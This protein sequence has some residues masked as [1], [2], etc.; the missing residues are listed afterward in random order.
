MPQITALILL[1]FVL[2]AWVAGSEADEIPVLDLAIFLTVLAV[3]LAVQS[4]LLLGLRGVLRKRTA[5]AETIFSAAVSGLF[6]ANVYF[7]FLLT[8]EAPSFVRVLLALAAG[9]AFFLLAGSVRVRAV[10]PLFAAAMILMSA[11][12]YGYARLIMAQGTSP[13]TVSLPVKSDRNVYIIGFESL[14]SPKAFRELYDVRDAPHVE[15]LKRLGF[16]VF[17][18]SY[19][20][21]F[22]T[23]SSYATMFEFARALRPGDLGKREVF[24]R[25]NS[26]FRSFHDSGYKIQFL[27][28]SNY[29]GLDPRTVDHFYPGVG[30]DSCKT[31]PKR[32]FYGFC[33]SR[34]V[35]LINETVFGTEKISYT[36]QIAH[37][38]KRIDLAVADKDPW[39]TISH[40]GHPFHTPKDFYWSDQGDIADFLTEMRDALPQIA[41]NVDATV[42]YIL[43]R[44]PD[45]V[46]IV[47][48]DH[49]ATMSRGIDVDSVLAGGVSAFPPKRFLEDRHGAF[50]AIYP[51]DFCTARTG[52]PIATTYLM[53]AI[54]ACLNDDDE[55][56]EAEKRRMRLIDLNGVRRSIDD[57]LA[58][59]VSHAKPGN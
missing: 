15:A 41:K 57:I 22:T 28:T 45:A 33:R 38:Q 50:L 7:C 55:P 13:G 8:V 27:Y 49:G 18:Q 46:V 5:R 39:L 20:S 10:V 51:A 59:A 48:G 23:L 24:L 12:Q 14:H 34:L 3:I 52:E 30:F 42:A 26:T 56:D 35:D 6:A 43:A 25:P 53:P 11:A 54:I 2:F 19:S 9:G 1:T 44:D 31:V 4:A 17:D 36:D 37:L 40:I 16:R 29:F 47:M 58:P 32:F 21:A